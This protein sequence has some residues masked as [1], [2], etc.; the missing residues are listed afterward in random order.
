VADKYSTIID[1]T[2][3]QPGISSCFIFDCRSSLADHQYG[4][5]AFNEAHIPQAQ[6]A[7]L[8]RQ[9]SGPIIPGQ[10]GRHPLPSREIFLQ[11][12]RDWGVTNDAQVI[13]Y[14]DNH[15]AFAARLWWMFRWLGHE[16]VAVM[17]GGFEEWKNAGLELATD[18]RVVTVS[19]FQEGQPLTKSV[20]ADDVLNQP[21]VL[22]DAR[23]A[24][25][26]RGEVE[27]IDKIAGH[28]PGATCLPFSDNLVDNKLKPVA[29]L[30]QRFL[31]AGIEPASPVTCYCGSGVTAAHNILALIHAGFDEPTLYPGSWS[32][33]I[34]NSER[35]IATGESAP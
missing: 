13:V 15:G 10:T 29:E 34:T 8:N 7:D 18:S 21:G 35:P 3:I 6:F 28:I 20:T 31:E 26:F 17:S 5:N 2:S 25:R 19:D 12:V 11:Q 9:L 14:D 32:D 33:W 23:D 16:A 27:P 22:T 24:A 4:Q 30:R 1:V